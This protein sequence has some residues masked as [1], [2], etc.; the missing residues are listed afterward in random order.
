MTAPSRVFA[1]L[2][3]ASLLLPP[4]AS[5]EPEVDAEPEAVTLQDPAAWSKCTSA[6]GRE[7]VVENREAIRNGDFEY[8]LS[9]WQTPAQ[10]ISVSST[11]AYLPAQA[12]DPAEGPV[13]ERGG[14]GADLRLPRGTPQEISLS[15]P[16][17]LPDEVN[18]LHLTF[19][20][21]VHKAYPEGYAEPLRVELIT[22]GTSERALWSREV[23]SDAHKD[24]AVLAYKSDLERG[25]LRFR[26][27]LDEPALYQALNQQLTEKRPIILRLTFAGQGAYVE[28]D[29][30]SLTTDGTIQWPEVEG[31]I[32]F[33][34]DRSTQS[35]GF[36]VHCTNA[37]ASVRSELMSARGEPYGLS[38][39]PGARA[40]ALASSHEE[41]YS[42]WYSDLYLFVPGF[43]LR[44]TNP[45]SHLSLIEQSL[46][47]GSVS[48][49][50][51]NDA[52]HPRTIEVYVQGGHAPTTLT[53][54]AHRT[55]SFTLKRVADLGPETEQYVIVRSRDS[56]WRAFAGVDVKGGGRATL[57]RP[58]VI[59]EDDE[60][61]YALSPHW[62]PDGSKL[63]FAGDHGALSTLDIGL[64]GAL[65]S[66]LFLL[67]PQPYGQATAWSP[68]DDRVLYT[69]TRGP[70]DQRGIWL[71]VPRESPRLLVAPPPEAT[72]TRDA[73]TPPPQRD[74]YIPHDPT[75]LPD[76]SGFIYS[77]PRC[78]NERA[79]DT[80][81]Y[82]Y[83]FGL[84]T[85]FRVARFFNEQIDHPTV[86]PDGR[87][88]AFIRT[89]DWSGF[90]PQR[91]R[92][93][94]LMRL[95]NASLM[96]PLLLDEQ[97]NHPTWSAK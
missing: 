61:Q 31:S 37:D 7:E 57:A 87:Y 83:Q 86:S 74:Q 17:H 75:W 52:D 30:L 48:G 53:V 82:L 58:L 9:G 67:F 49:E 89:L 1:A 63:V 3:L 10:G 32:A 94:W 21:R 54:A 85:N 95:G 77:L 44:L 84:E 46:K 29:E 28:L 26:Y 23:L 4:L 16:L 70:F 66:P 6:Q 92:E 27:T 80:D 15:Q 97:P 88:V 40:L 59:G 93:L 62:S 73:P 35:S 81:L 69:V 91:R 36:A 68:V 64:P 41:A 13:P 51:V 18:T 19:Y 72:P 60:H 39:R 90:R 24:A 43:L 8:G 78:K 47:T 11:A 65:P 25:W 45:P 50:V 56:T 96:W 71:A 34:V 2:I 12:Q 22:R 33:T 5:G 20:F 14:F 76:G 38:W 55:R 79:C 42:R